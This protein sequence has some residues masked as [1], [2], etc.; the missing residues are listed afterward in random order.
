VYQESC[1]FLGIDPQGGVDFQWKQVDASMTFV[2]MSRATIEDK[3]LETNNIEK[4]IIVKSVYDVGKTE[5]AMMRRMF[6]FFF[7]YFFKSPIESGSSQMFGE[8]VK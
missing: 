8:S 7:T 2:V 5:D 4:R 6:F 3:F 1:I